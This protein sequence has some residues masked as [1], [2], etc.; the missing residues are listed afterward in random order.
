MT[1][2]P[3]FQDENLCIKICLQPMAGINFQLESY[4]FSKKTAF[5]AKI[6]FVLLKILFESIYYNLN[7]F[8]STKCPTP[9]V[10]SGT[11]SN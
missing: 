5:M 11:G 1:H 4:K 2:D 7:N 9:E 8:P 6:Y 10:M 3:L